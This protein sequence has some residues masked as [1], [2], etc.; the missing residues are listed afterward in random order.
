MISGAQAVQY[1]KQSGFESNRCE[2]PW[3]GL[4]GGRKIQKDFLK[5]MGLA[6]GL[7]GMLKVGL[8]NEQR[9]QDVLD[10]VNA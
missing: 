7:I 3:R 6:Q 2:M 5:E 9:R 4:L 1:R 10:V 8:Q